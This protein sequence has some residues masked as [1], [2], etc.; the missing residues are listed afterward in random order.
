MG[1]DNPLWKSEDFNGFRKRNMQVHLDDPDLLEPWAHLSRA[2]IFV[3]SM[4]S[5]SYVPAVLNPNCVLYP[6]TMA[7]VPENWIN[8]LDAGKPSFDSKLRSCLSRVTGK[9]ADP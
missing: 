3:M 4:S 6:G 8:A 7:S 5:F 1:K 2:H 9:P